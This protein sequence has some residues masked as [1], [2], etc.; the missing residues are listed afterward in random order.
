M[1]IEAAKRRYSEIVHML[2][3]HGAAPDVR[4][5]TDR[6]P[7]F[8]QLLL[9]MLKQYNHCSNAMLIVTT[10]MLVANQLRAFV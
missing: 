7:H 5:S 2:V 9:K 10:L 1:I 8:G 6:S 3:A 4:D